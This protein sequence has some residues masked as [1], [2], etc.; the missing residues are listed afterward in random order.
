MDLFT[1]IFLDRFIGTGSN[2]GNTDKMVKRPEQIHTRT[3]K[4]TIRVQIH[5]DILSMV[6]C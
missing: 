3:H 2:R 1:H 5:W 4:N 6:V